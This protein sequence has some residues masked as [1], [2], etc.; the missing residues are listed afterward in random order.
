MFF[1]S[2]FC[3]L[4]KFGMVEHV[5]FAIMI[6]VHAISDYHAH[7]TTDTIC[8]PWTAWKSDR[9]TK[10]IVTLLF[11]DEFEKRKI[12]IKAVYTLFWDMMFFV[13]Y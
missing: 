6:C 12:P 8:N 3:F 2:V 13:S 4:C 7:N 5:Q 9:V 11:N 1:P 10:I